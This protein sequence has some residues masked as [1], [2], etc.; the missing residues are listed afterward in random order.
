MQ[1]F[2][3]QGLE[4]LTTKLLLNDNYK[5]D[6][7]KHLAIE[8]FLIIDQFQHKNLS[9][10][11]TVLIQMNNLANL[12]IHSNDYKPDYPVPIITAS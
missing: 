2:G 5:L 9:K 4:F 10:K 8:R 7:K 11:S 6:N 12:Y 3:V 1:A